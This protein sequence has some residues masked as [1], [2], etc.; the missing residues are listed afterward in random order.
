[1]T[2]ERVPSAADQEVQTNS[3]T[4]IQPR[5]SSPRPEHQRHPDLSNEVAALSTKLIQAINQ[6]TQLDDALLSTRHELAAARDRVVK[7]EAAAKEHENL[8]KQGLLVRRTETVQV[9]E[10]LRGEIV[11]ERRRRNAA[12]KDKR[13]LELELENLTSSLFEEA[14]TMVAD[15]RREHAE[16]ERRAEQLK[17]RLVDSEALLVNHQQQLR[18]LKTVLHRIQSERDEED[19]KTSATPATPVPTTHDG[20]TGLTGE[21]ANPGSEEPAKFVPQHPLYFTTLIQPVLRTDLQ[22]YDDFNLLLNSSTN[23]PATSRAQSGNFAGLNVRG[24]GS[25][26]NPI[27]STI[28]NAMQSATRDT[29]TLSTASTPSTPTQAAGALTPNSP[30]DVGTSLKESRFYKRVLPE[31]IEPTLRLDMAPGLSWLARRTLLGSMAQ[32]SLTIEPIAAPHAAA[33]ASRHPAPPC[34]LCGEVRRD[35]DFHRRHTFRSGDADDAQ[36]YPL[37]PFCLVRV[38]ATCDFVAFLRAVKAGFWRSGGGGGGGEAATGSA[39]GGAAWEEC[40]RLRE[41]MFWARLGGGVV[42]FGAAVQEAPGTRLSEE[43]R[44]V[45]VGSSAEP[46]V[47]PV[48]P[49]RPGARRAVSDVMG[50]ERAG[51]GKG[52][53]GAFS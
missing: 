50:V 41:R 39:V 38:R 7:L 8:L 49:L 42:P 47:P 5:T 16:S 48:L 6:Q 28:T 18:E 27:Q 40:A 33:A 31:D 52:M 20:T 22:S 34:A 21:A 19:I 23:A 30:S 45:G 26:A 43:A 14:N 32:G 9:E 15:A 25:L 17:S 35:P 46:A 1:M 37:C 53:P 13:S 51:D 3:A 11:E 36:R 10:N 4:A 12:E 44:S 29:S 24:L 2:V